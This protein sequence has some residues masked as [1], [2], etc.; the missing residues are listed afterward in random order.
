MAEAAAYRGERTRE[1]RPEGV[2][3]SIELTGE[4][5]RGWDE[6]V[7]LCVAEAAETLQSITDVQVE[8][9]RGKIRDGSI[10]SYQV[11]CKVVFR[12]DEKLRSH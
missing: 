6:A 5:K 4:S 7:K 8:E 10:Y 11:R 9:M 1:E 12:I 2:Y 3:K